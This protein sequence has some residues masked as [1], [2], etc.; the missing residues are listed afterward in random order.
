MLTETEM[1]SS[2]ILLKDCEKLKQEF[3]NLKE[4][5]DI[6][7]LLDVTYDRLIYHIYGVPDSKKYCNF[8]ITAGKP[9]DVELGRGL[10]REQRSGLTKE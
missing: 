8:S 9:A 3:L 6:A 5:R 10:S 7:A 4:P 1:N 2:L